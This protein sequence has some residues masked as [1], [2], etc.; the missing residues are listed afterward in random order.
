MDV[1]QRGSGNQ[2]HEFG[3]GLPAADKEVLVEYLKTL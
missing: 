2:G 3:T 1:S